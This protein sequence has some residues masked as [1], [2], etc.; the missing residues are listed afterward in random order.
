MHVIWGGTARPDGI[1]FGELSQQRR[2][3]IYLPAVCLMFTELDFNHQ[4]D[5][6]VLSHTT[7]VIK[8]ASLVPNSKKAKHG[9]K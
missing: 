7:L 5:I 2:L 8:P 1:G 4:L 9:T 6:L 3:N